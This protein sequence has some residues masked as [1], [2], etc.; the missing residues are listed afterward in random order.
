MVCIS[1]VVPLYERIKKKIKSYHITKCEAISG[2]SLVEYPLNSF[3]PPSLSPPTPQSISFVWISLPPF[4]SSDLH[5]CKTTCPLSSIILLLPA[6]ISSGISKG[7]LNKHRN[8]NLVSYHCLQTF[9]SSSF[10]L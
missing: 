8:I 7:L 3:W 5:Q 6:S 1:I 4:P 2:V 9:T 10:F